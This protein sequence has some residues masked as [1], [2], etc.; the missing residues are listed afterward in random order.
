[1]SEQADAVLG[2]RMMP[3]Y[4]GPLKGRMPLYKYVGNRI[5]TWFENR[6]LG[7]RLT[8]FHSGYRAYRLDA[9]R[10]IELSRMAD[11]FHFDTQIIVKLHHQRFRI[12]EI[13]I[14]T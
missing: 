3:T 10:R 13:P 11:G 8:E 4:G 1:V 6:A 12:K 9:L 14:P 2:S 7:T 5:L